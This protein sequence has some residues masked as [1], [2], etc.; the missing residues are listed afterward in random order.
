MRDSSAHSL[1]RGPR[2]GTLPEGPGGEREQAMVGGVEK[3]S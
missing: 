3:V 2:P 1:T